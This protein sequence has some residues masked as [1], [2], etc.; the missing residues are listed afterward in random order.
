[1]IYIDTSVV[2]VQLL[3]EDHKPP[4]AL[5]DERLIASRLVEYETWTRLHARNLAESHGEA[6]RTLLARI[7]MVELSPL[8]LGRALE[9]FPHP[10]APWMLFTWPRWTTSEANA[11][12]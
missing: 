8:V 12:K 11:C 9:A 2:L 3:A 1:M 7:S 5:W 6:A 4:R 10:S